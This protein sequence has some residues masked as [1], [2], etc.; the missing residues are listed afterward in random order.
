MWMQQLPQ[1]GGQTTTCKI[2]DEI[3]DQFLKFKTSKDQANHCFVM[4]INPKSLEVVVDYTSDNISIE[5]IAAELPPSAPRYIAYSYKW[6]HTDGRVSYPLVFIYYCPP[7]INTKLN[8]LY[9]S[10]KPIIVEALQVQKLLSVEDP[11]KMTETWL[12]EKL[13]F[14]K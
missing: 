1:Q 8:I 5:Q 10:T 11:E 9:A 12:K 14:F 4:K 13:D 6:E 7:G 3:K 2:P